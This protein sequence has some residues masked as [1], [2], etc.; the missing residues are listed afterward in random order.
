MTDE[1]LRTFESLGGDA[2]VPNCRF[3]PKQTIYQL[4]KSLRRQFRGHLNHYF[5]KIS[6]GS[7]IFPI[8]TATNSH[9]LAPNSF[10]F[11][12]MFWVSGNTSIIRYSYRFCSWAVAENGSHCAMRTVTVSR[13]L[14][15]ASRWLC[16]TDRP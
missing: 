16:T 11:V 4:K 5:L 2:F 10:N 3:R 13:R 6:L 12:C 1:I 15:P 8:E 14:A 9:P 7:V